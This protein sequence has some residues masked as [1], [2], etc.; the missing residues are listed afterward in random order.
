MKKVKVSHLL[1]FPE[2]RQSTNFS[3]GASSV[4]AVM[5]YYGKN[6]REDNLIKYMNVKP[7]SIEHSGVRPQDMVDFLVKQNLQAKLHEGADLA[8]L[9]RF[10]DKD[11]PVIVA[12]QAWDDRNPGVEFY[13]TSYQNG[14][15]V[16][17]IG[18]GPEVVVFDDP[19]VLS[20]HAYLSNEEFI[21]RWH[22][23]DSTGQR[24]NH[25]AIPVYGKKPVFKPNVLKKIK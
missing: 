23:A 10:I 19:S 11:I 12:I 2:T 22:D 18:Y 20:N 4:Q 6:I 9:K 25:L 3:C 15:Y 5:Y 7:T 17:V 8:L 1:R 21:D 16:V 14:H 24:Y 13:K